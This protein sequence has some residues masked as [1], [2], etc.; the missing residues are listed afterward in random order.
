MLRGKGGA[1]V[2]VKVR[3]RMRVM[4]FTSLGG[5][6]VVVRGRASLRVSVGEG[7]G[8]GKIQGAG[9]GKIQCWGEGDGLLTSLG[10]RPVV[11]HAFGFHVQ[12]WIY[13]GLNKM[14][15]PVAQFQTKKKNG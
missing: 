12:L 15:S 1:R 5:M 13:T 9:K 2:S 7:E 8:M 4:L 3:I 14:I 11:C 10:G 6:P